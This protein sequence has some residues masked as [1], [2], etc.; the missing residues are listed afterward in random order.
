MAKTPTGKTQPTGTQLDVVRAAVAL[1]SKP[2]VDHLLYVGDLPLPEEVFRGKPRARKK[3]VQAVVGPS[4]RSVIEQE[5]IPVLPLPEYD[6]GRPEKLKIALVSGIARGIYKEGDVVVGLLARKPAAYP[7][8]ILV[9]TVG[10]EEGE[11]SFGFLQAEGVSPGVMD[12]LIE[13][14]FFGALPDEERLM[15]AVARGERT[16]HY[17]TLRRKRDGECIEVSLTLS[18]VFYRSEIVGVASIARDI[19]HQKKVEQALNTSEKLAAV[20]RLAATIAHEINNPLEAITNL[21][22]LAQGHTKDGDGELFLKQAQQELERVALLTKQTLGFY[23]ESKGAREL[24]LEEIVLPLVAAFS[25]RSRIKQVSVET[26]FRQNPTIVG[27]PGEMRQLFANLLNNSIDAVKGGGRIS[28]F[29]ID[30]GEGFVSEDLTAKL[31]MPT[32]NTAMF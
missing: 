30:R 23:R 26:E 10:P 5:G 18:P 4:Q 19:S 31:G 29:I 13:P 1:A 27:V 7:D 32:A 12:T 17:E 14:S 2:N 15:S 11:G 28:A 3:L 24:T 22:F 8:S 25:A 6:L 21:V 20:G 16:K 9:V